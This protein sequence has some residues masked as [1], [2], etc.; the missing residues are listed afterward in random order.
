MSVRPIPEGYHTLTPYLT[1]K[2]VPQMIEFLKNAFEAKEISRST[3]PDGRIANVELKIGDSMIMLGESPRDESHPMALYM[4]VV[5]ADAT[6]ARAVQVGAKSLM[7]PADQ[8]YGDRLGGVTDHVGN[9]WW[10]ATRKEN[11]SPE[12]IERRMASKKRPD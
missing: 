4:Y 5:D 9:S 11:V 10:I 8:I 7:P 2:G 3:L 1:L 12:E 6:Y